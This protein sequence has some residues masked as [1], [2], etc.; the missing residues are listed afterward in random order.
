MAF[1][2]QLT[3]RPQLG[4]WHIGRVNLV[5][6]GVQFLIWLQT[7]ARGLDYVQERPPS[8]T[9]AI[10]LRIE[11]TLPLW[12]W[13]AGFLLAAFVLFV[14]VSGRWWHVI[15]TGHVI[16]AVMYG[17]FAAG[18]ALQIPIRSTLLSVGGAALLAGGVYLAAVTSRH[19]WW[20]FTGSVVAT[21]VGGWVCGTGLGYDFRTSTGFIVA[22]AGHLCYALGI[23][24][25]ATRTKQVP[26]EIL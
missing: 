1:I 26:G 15:V 11:Q 13:G 22:C 5:L 2:H 25:L 16:G 18:S 7:A 9:P 23:A 4:D 21:G 20:R 12:V 24:W 14:G 3:Q 8:P 19:D 17:S 10:L 6:A